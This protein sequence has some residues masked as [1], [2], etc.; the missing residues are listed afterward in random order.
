MDLEKFIA[1]PLGTENE[2]EIV[3]LTDPETGE[4][5]EFEGWEVQPHIM[6]REP[7]SDEALKFNSFLTAARVNIDES[8]EIKTGQAEMTINE[9]P[10]L[11]EI[12]K[13]IVLS[14]VLP[15]KSDKEGELAKPFV[16]KKEGR[17][18][19]H[20]F[21]SLLKR[22]GLKHP[23]T[24]WYRRFCWELIVRINPSDKVVVEAKNS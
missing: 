24:E 15:V 18:A 8:G 3:W 9:W 16:F 20:Q 2:P 11:E 21:I 7:Y 12:A 19:N 4:K 17:R 5:V 14:G 1:P 10:L 13:T 22:I 23:I 6:V